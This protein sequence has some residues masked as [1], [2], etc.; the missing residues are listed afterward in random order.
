MTTRT[1]DTAED[2]TVGPNTVAYERYGEISLESGSVVIYDVEN[3]SAW[4]Q[5]DGA[6]QRTG[7]R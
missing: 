1:D 3:E 5:S 6:V 2:H 7:V 4:I